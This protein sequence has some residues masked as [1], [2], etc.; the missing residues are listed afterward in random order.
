MK[1][2]CASDFHIGYQDANYPKIKEFFELVKA[3]AG[4]LILCGMSWIYDAV[5]L[6]LSKA[7]NL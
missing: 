3:N 4:E 7:R 6:K 5:L 2:Y 1:I